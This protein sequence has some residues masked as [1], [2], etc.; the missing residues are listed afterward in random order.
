MDHREKFLRATMRR[1]VEKGRR[2]NKLCVF[3]EDRAARSRRGNAGVT[4]TSTPSTNALKT[5]NSLDW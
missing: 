4:P 2:K 3:G 5:S 1:I